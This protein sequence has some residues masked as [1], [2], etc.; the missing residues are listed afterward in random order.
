MSQSGRDLLDPWIV[1]VNAATELKENTTRN[2][3]VSILKDIPSITDGIL[4]NVY[5]IY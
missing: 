5:T 4:N 1:Q 3:V 2:I